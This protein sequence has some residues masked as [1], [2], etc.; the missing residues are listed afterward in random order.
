M[1]FALQ[2]LTAK[3]TTTVES[4]RA[5]LA[6]AKEEISKL[7]QDMHG[8]RRT[9]LGHNQLEELRNLQVGYWIWNVRVYKVL[10][11]EKCNSMSDS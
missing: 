2:N 7:S 1:L 5:E 8:Q 11:Y 6:E 10:M 3:Q 9:V 4:L